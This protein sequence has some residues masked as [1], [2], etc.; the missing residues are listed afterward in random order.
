[1]HSESWGRASER[2]RGDELCSSIDV[3][4]VD[5]PHIIGS[6]DIPE[7]ATPAIRK[8]PLLQQ[9]AHSTIEEQWLWPLDELLECVHGDLPATE[10]GTYC[11]FRTQSTCQKIAGVRSSTASQR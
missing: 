10:W 6:L 3:L 11:P 2:V 9:G 1:M 5:P 7:L 4:L 8:S